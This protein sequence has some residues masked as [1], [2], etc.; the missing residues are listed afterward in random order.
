MSYSDMYKSIGIK[1]ELNRLEAQVNIGWEKELRTLKLLGLKDN[2]KILEIGSGPGFV[3]ERL[4]NAFPSSHIVCLDIDE[5]MLNIAKKRLLHYGNNRLSIMQGNVM[6]MKIKDDL[7][8]FVVVRLVFQHLKDPIGALKEI[9]RVLKPGGKVIITD[10]DSG[11]WGVSEPEV[12]KVINKFGNIQKAGGG[13]RKIGRKLLKI[14][15]SS[16]FID[17][18]F[19]AVVKH[20]DMD[21]MD[22]LKPKVDIDSIMKN[23]NFNKEQLRT[24]I[25]MYDNISDSTESVVILILLMA[26]GRK[27]SNLIET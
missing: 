3:T 25:S 11:M 15:K 12:N 8:D 20:S 23:N 9:F 2:V 13:D 10:I 6:N 7:F 26:S 19:E 4:L 27:P 5:V 16:G 1:T 18:D 17:L 22:S 24:I 14:L 21:G